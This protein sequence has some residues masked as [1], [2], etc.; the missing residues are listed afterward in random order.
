MTVP[1]YDLISTGFFRQIRIVLPFRPNFLRN[2]SPACGTAI[3]VPY[4]IMVFFVYLAQSALP[5]E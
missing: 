4:S 2:E 3:A 5:S 1:Q